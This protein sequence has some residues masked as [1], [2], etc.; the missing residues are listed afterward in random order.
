MAAFLTMNYWYFF[1]FS[2]TDPCQWLQK[3]FYA[4]WILNLFSGWFMKM[5][6]MCRQIV[7]RNDIVHFCQWLS[8]PL[9]MFTS[10]KLWHCTTFYIFRA[11]L[12]MLSC[13]RHLSTKSSICLHFLLDEKWHNLP[14][15]PLLFVFTVSLA[16]RHCVGQ[17]YMLWAVTTALAV[18]MSLE[19]YNP[20]AYY[21]IMKTE[22]K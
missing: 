9:D 21:E 14:R 3:Y 10:N 15:S 6:I 16:T 1:F 11:L 13:S 19:N 4:T 17:Y 22:M 12:L 2:K 7:L 18:C 20:T 5:Q 8:L